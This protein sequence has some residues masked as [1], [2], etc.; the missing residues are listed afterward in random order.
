[1]AIANKTVVALDRR[2]QKLHSQRSQWEKHWQE[3]A[4][5]MLPRKADI[6]KKRTQG[7]KRTELI[8]DSTA[9]HAVE[10]LA[11]SL[12]GM[13]TSPSS[14]WFSMRYRDLQLAQND[15][16]NEWLEGCVELINKEFQ[17][18]NFQQEI[19]EL[20]YDLVVFGTG[21]LFVDFDDEGLRFSTRHIAEI[22]ISED[23]NDRVDTVYRKFQLN[24]RQ[25]AQRFGEENL[26]DKVKKDL[27]KDPYQDHDIIHVVYPRADNLGS[28][29]I[30][31]PVGSIYYHA[32]SKALLG[33]G[34]FD[35]LP[36][37]V[38]RFNKDSVSIYGRS[39]AM[40]CLPDVKM[41]NK[42]SEVSIRAAQ[43]Q[44]DPPLM[45]PDDGFL[46]PVRTTPGALNF[47][48]TGTRDR[49]EPLQAGA[50]NPIG[51]AMEEQ[52][53][54]AIRAAFY[55][56]QL[57]LQ[58]GP[59][60]TATQ[61]LALQEQQMRSLGSVMGRLQH[62]L[63]QPL[64]QRSFKLMLRKGRLD[65][66]PEELQGQDIDIEYVSPLAKAQKLTDL[67][68]MMRG[69]EV[70]LQLGQSLPVMDYIDD[71]GLVKY[72]VDVAGMP[73]KV[74]KSNEEVA[75]LREQQA[76]Q[77][78]QLAQQQQEMMNA[79]QAQKAAPLLKVL[80]EAEQAEAPPAA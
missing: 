51:I 59:Q 34:G 21:C 9:I 58:T 38:P 56:D 40:S 78:A 31:K 74:I 17:R 43:K 52:R 10:L 42:M 7:D 80:S 60:M 5:Y 62:E 6:T 49:L 53:R 61:V 55:V 23:M 2:Y 8:F 47:Y 37:M 79:E 41:V 3:L 33:E 29:P 65:V 16:A 44:I 35:E 4:D 1:M 13:L 66:P 32:E 72:L 64:I 71:D 50:T 70:L 77:Q 20:Y 68:S 75:A 69:L 18:S 63:L 46:L 27:D 45:V 22:L 36:F 24:A 39:P 48:R 30:R 73:A 15:A 67:Q 28:S 25:L 12:H 14:P 11:S 76:Q 54:N 57:Q 26:P 19:Y